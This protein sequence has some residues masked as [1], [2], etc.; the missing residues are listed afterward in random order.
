MRK[1]EL[2]EE[3]A[4]LRRELDAA[5]RRAGE[6]EH[7]L[8]DLREWV[9][10]KREEELAELERIRKMQNF[11]AYDGRPQEGAEEG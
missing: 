11:W 3:N 1:R 4:R 7:S 6:L 5:N 8:E 2:A 10:Q 9:R